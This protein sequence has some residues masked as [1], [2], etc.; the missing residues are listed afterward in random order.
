MT[1]PAILVLAGG[2]YG[3]K[4]AGVTLLG[5]GDTG[6]RLLPLT[7]LIPAALFAGLIVALS[8]GDAA[9]LPLARL[10][11][12]AAASLAAWR[13]APFIVVVGIAVATTALLRAL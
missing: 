2:A 1:W 11:G 6:R 12:V 3:L 13:K 4:V 7:T 5:S 10:A 9:G 8:F